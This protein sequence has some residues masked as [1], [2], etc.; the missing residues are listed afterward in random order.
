MPGGITLILYPFINVAFF[1]ILFFHAL[2]LHNTPWQL[3]EHFMLNVG[4]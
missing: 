3:G 4:S 1:Q 2:D